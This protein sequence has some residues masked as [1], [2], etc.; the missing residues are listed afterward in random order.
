M[1]I[2]IVLTGM[3]GSGKSDL[4]IELEG[5]GYQHVSMSSALERYAQQRISTAQRWQ[6]SHRLRTE[7]GSDFLARDILERAISSPCAVIDGA[8]TLSEAA[9]FQSAATVFQLVAFQRP[10]ALRYAR[11]RARGNNHYRHVASG[12]IDLDAH[13]L[14]LGTAH[15]IAVA[16]YIYFSDAE[17]GDPL[18]R[19]I[20]QAAVL[21]HE[22]AQEQARRIRNGEPVATN[23]AD[24]AS[25]QA[26]VESGS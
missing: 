21:I 17:D 20:A 1:D 22:R 12:T 10:P 11:L 2:C 15:L 4:A 25:L 3:P 9:V 16:D 7:H 13:E 18:R 8:R 6:L 5:M 24:Y 19:S 26:L 23:R 14:V